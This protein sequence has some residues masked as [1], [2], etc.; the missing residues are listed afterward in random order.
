MS[1]RNE[2]NPFLLYSLLPDKAKMLIRKWVEK[3]TPEYDLEPFRNELILV[4]DPFRQITQARQK[5][6][7][8]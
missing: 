3:K 5:T 2:H 1:Y 4:S 6:R 7:L 8:A